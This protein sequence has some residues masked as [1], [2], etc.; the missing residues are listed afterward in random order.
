MAHG[1]GLDEKALTK[2]G[3]GDDISEI[4]KNH[5][6]LG[7]ALGLAATPSFVIDGVALLGY[8]GRDRLQAIVDAAGRCGKVVC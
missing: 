6:K 8:P 4:M 1:L 3:D 7:D 5:V 2:A